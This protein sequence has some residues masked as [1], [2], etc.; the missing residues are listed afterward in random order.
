MRC[1]LSLT[2]MWASKRLPILGT[3]C[4]SA[5]QPHAKAA[6]CTW[7]CFVPG[8]GGADHPQTFPHI[9]LVGE[10]RHGALALQ[11]VPWLQLD[12]VPR[13]LAL[14]VA[15]HHLGPH[16][17]RSMPPEPARTVIGFRDEVA[18]DAG[19]CWL[20][21]TLRVLH[22]QGSNACCMLCVPRSMIHLAPDQSGPW[23]PPCWLG[24]TA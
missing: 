16:T 22:A 21:D 3:L 10:L 12:Y 9:G 11:R 7:T 14:R 4:G 18:A 24:C 5:G 13:H 23:R 19:Y 17:P 20:L 8:G 1:S 6:I 2:L 15:L